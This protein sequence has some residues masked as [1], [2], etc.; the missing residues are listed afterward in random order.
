MKKRNFNYDT[1][2]VSD[3]IVL[4][5]INGQLVAVSGDIR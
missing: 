3:D 2:N 5:N 1:T 4:I